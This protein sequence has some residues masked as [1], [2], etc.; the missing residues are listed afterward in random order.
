M[1]A[2]GPRA[3]IMRD[4]RYYNVDDDINSGPR[5][6]IN[7]NY[8]GGLTWDTLH[9]ITLGYPVQNPTW[10]VRNAAKE[11]MFQLQFLLP[12]QICREHLS[13]A[14][15]STFPLNDEIFASRK[16]FGNFVVRLRDHVKKT[17]VNSGHTKIHT[18]EEDVELRLVGSLQRFIIYTKHPVW[19]Y[20]FVAL[21]SLLTMSWLL[22]A[23]PAKPK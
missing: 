18:F 22:E 7:T 16:A 3:T 20:S 19:F 2:Q 5:M 4:M 11:F 6:P 15:Q 8:W 1:S 21:V 23:K 9:Y 10:K 14:Y 13:E 12:C 17:H